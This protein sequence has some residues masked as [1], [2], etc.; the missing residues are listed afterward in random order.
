[1][2]A[3]ISSFVQNLRDNGYTVRYRDRDGKHTFTI[4]DAGN[5]PEDIMDLKHIAFSHN[6]SLYP[7]K[8]NAEYANFRAEVNEPTP[9]PVTNADVPQG[10]LPSWQWS[11]VKQVKA[12]TRSRDRTQSAIDK[13]IVHGRD[14][15]LLEEQLARTEDLLDVLISRINLHGL[16]AYL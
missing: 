7:G 9:A 6:L 8:S 3:Q 4:S 5:P 2:N 1:M 16:S 13:D 11:L 14:R 12:V 10:R 15:D